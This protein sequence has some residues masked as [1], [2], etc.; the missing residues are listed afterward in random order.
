MEDAIEHVM[1]HIHRYLRVISLSPAFDAM[2]SN[3]LSERWRRWNSF[4]FDM[5]SQF[6]SENVMGWN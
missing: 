5:D 3:H 1:L 2:V 6:Y 4:M